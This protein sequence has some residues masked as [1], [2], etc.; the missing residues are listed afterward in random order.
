MAPLGIATAVNGKVVAAVLRPSKKLSE[1]DNVVIIK[2]F[3]G[4]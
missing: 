3:Y 2:A 4:G 1:G